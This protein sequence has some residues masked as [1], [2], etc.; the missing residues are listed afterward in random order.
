MNP[1]IQFTGVVKTHN[2]GVRAL[3]GLS[4]SVPK[5]VVFGF[6]GLNGAGKTS[7]IRIL[8]GI[9]AQDSGTVSVFG[10]AIHHGDSEFK[11][12]IGF[13]LDEPLYFDWMNAV[14]YL[15]FVGAM[16]D[17]SAA[18]TASRSG[19]LIEFFDLQPDQPIKYYST[20][21]K[22]KISLAAAIIHKPALI[23]LDEPLE[24]IDA[25]AAIAVKETLAL[26]A[27][28]G[29]TVF[30]TS[31]VLDT[32]EKL[33]GEIAIVHQGKLLVQ[34]ASADIRTSMKHTLTNQ[35]YSSLEELF[36]D[37]VSHPGAE[38]RLSFL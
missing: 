27:S 29:T 18:E 33:C 5:G 32:V 23:I 6:I 11:R 10:N 19:E 34:C 15:K 20:G 7:S 37:R 31:H 14:E 26:M 13:V 30:I 9:S 35:T 21:M 12:S 24:G 25:L 38:R 16:Y 3:D 36:L 28:R 4:F 22:K 1:V 17:L 2:N 8:A